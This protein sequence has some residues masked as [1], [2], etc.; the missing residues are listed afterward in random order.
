MDALREP[1][2]SKAQPKR[3]AHHLS[4]GVGT[5][6]DQLSRQRL[7]QR[8]LELDVD[9]A[10]AEEDVARTRAEYSRL[11]GEAEA[12]AGEN[13]ALR[14]ELG[15][16][17][18][19]RAR[20]QRLVARLTREVHAVAAAEATTSGSAGSRGPTQRTQRQSSLAALVVELEAGLAAAGAAAPVAEDDDTPAWLQ[21]AAQQLTAPAQAAQEQPVPEQPVPEQP[22]PEQTQ[23]QATRGD[24]P[25]QATGEA[26][27]SGSEGG[28]G[29]EG[30]EG[31]DGSGGWERAASLFHQL[32]EV[33]LQLYASRAETLSCRAEAATQIAALQEQLA[34]GGAARAEWERKAAT[35]LH[36]IDLL[37]SAGAPRRKKPSDCC[38][39]A[40]PS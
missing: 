10:R 15:R 8:I 27:P 29:G 22:A 24:L 3:Q 4:A 7:Q 18:T 5:S 33:R 19:D 2:L 11:H 9:V 25:A 28:E 23:Q 36:R 30:G 13:A 32:D 17:Q 40:Y 26:V 16:E 21:D 37:E 20:L 14:S 35:L 6:T 12:L 31:D 39:S 34:E 38:P 1:L